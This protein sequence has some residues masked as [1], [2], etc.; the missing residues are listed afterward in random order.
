MYDTSGCGNLRKR[1]VSLLGLWHSYKQANFLIWRRFAST[2]MAPLFHNLFPT[3][4]FFIKP[5]TLTQIVNLLTIIRMAYPDFR[6]ALLAAIDDVNIDRENRV[7]AVNLRDLC[8]FF[9]PV[10]TNNAHIS[11]IRTYNCTIY[12]IICHP[13]NIYRSTFTMHMIQ[14]YDHHMKTPYQR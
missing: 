1:C 10:V 7:M 4:Q 12:T 5:T 9:I 3:S 13:D 14:V 6:E 8:E 2:I 11:T